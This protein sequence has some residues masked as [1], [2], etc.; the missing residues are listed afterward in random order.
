[1]KMGAHRSPKFA[2][3]QDRI[4]FCVP[5]AVGTLELLWE[6]TMDQ[7]PQGDVGKW[8]DS[9][10]EHACHWTGKKGWLIAALIDTG[11]IDE[12]AECRLV[13]H[14]WPDHAPDFLKKRLKRQGLIPLSAVADKRSPNGDQTVTREGKGIEEKGIEGKGRAHGRQ[15]V[16]QVDCPLLES[17]DPEVCR[18]ICEKKNVTPEALAYAIEKLADWQT[19]AGNPKASQ[20]RTPVAWAA[21]LRNG[22][23][24]DFLL[25]GF[26]QGANGEVRRDPTGNL[27]TGDRLKAEIR[28]K[29]AENLKVVNP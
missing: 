1:M 4:G 27:A 12:C 14:D 22:L 2:D 23:H 18:K 28:R 6:F 24:S 26:S 11:W 8:P 20:K 3:F 9:A 21:C 15:T 10:I 17:W 5:K 19:A 25:K 13:I 7:S 29:S 16:T